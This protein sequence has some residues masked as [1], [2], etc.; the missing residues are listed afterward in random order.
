VIFPLR[1]KLALLTSTLLVLGIGTV[2]S[3]LFSQ[4]SQALETEARKRGRYIAQSLALNARDAVLLEDDVFLTK[5][6]ETVTQESEV[7][8][9][10]LL[11]SEGDLIASTQAREVTHRPR[12]TK[13]TKLAFA[14]E[15]RRL[16]VASR[17]TF[18]D[19]DLGEA[20]VVLDLY[21]IVGVVIERSRRDLYVASGGLLMIGI[22]IAFATS[23]RITRPLSRLR[24]AVNALAKGDVTARVPVTTRDELADLTHAFNEMSESLE[25]KQRVETAFRRYVSDHVLQQVL[26]EPESVQLLGE[27]R[28]ITVLFIDIRQFTRLAS[29]IDPEALV[30]FLNEAFELITDR[31]LQHGATVDKYIGD[32]ILAYFGAPIESSDHCD[33]AVA[34]AIAVQRSVE[35]R[36][37]ALSSDNA[38]FHHLAL[39]IGIQ[40][41]PV[42]VGNI[43]SELKM[44]YTIIGDAVNVA[45]RL[46]KLAPAGEI[47]ISSD[48]A[49]KVEDRIQLESLG[50]KALEGR[51]EPV[52]VF[53]VLY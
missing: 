38:E 13:A 51:D 23:G 46:Q 20:Q 21:A 41:G 5:M 10:R 33:R 27:R 28:D 39:G 8:A 16:V 18:R 2:A 48:V 3:L 22:L 45:N 24:V 15:P 37:K 53:R 6:L 44:D 43:G 32:A 30:A 7:V 19:V 52:E 26:D 12:M 1:L 31:L 35:E 17:L 36:N 49:R 9:A 29:A 50:E 40:T 11:N 42:L 14:S 47:L 4:Y 25:E 34:A